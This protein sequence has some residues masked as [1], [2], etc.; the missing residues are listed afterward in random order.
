MRSAFANE[1]E[2]DEKEAARFTRPL[3]P[4]GGIGLVSLLLASAR[5]PKDDCLAASA[6]PVR[7]GLMSAER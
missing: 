7:A 6:E 4:E 3:D 2:E 5:L 1:L